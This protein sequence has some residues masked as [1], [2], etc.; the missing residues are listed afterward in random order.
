MVT[1]AAKAGRKATPTSKAAF[2]RSPSN[3][4]TPVPPLDLSKLA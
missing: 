3:K 2:D 1:P 4:K